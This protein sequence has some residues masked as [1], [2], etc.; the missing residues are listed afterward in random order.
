MLTMLNVPFSYRRVRAVGC[1]Q[2]TAFDTALLL[3]LPAGRTAVVTAERAGVQIAIR[4][5]LCRVMERAF[6][7]VMR[8]TGQPCAFGFDIVTAIV[9]A[10]RA[11]LQ[12]L[13]GGLVRGIHRGVVP[14]G[15]LK[16]RGR[17]LAL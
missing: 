4:R 6:R 15:L 8:V 11:L 5:M 16:A 3:H 7:R 17:R 12:R 9:A 13:S 14:R 10:L 2:M 1:R